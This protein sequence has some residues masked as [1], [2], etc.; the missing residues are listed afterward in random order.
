MTFLAL[1]HMWHATQ[2]MGRGGWWRF[3][4]FF[5]LAHMWHATQLIGWWMMTFL[6]LDM[7]HAT[8][9]V[10]DDVSCTRTHVTC[11]ATDRVGWM[12]T[13]SICLFP[14]ASNLP[15]LPVSFQAT[16][17]VRGKTNDFWNNSYTMDML[18]KRKT[19]EREVSNLPHL[20]MFLKPHAKYVEK[21][22]VLEPNLTS[23]TCCQ[24]EETADCQPLPFSTSFK[25][26]APANVFE[27]TRKIR[28][29]V[30]P[31]QCSFTNPNFDV[32]ELETSKN[33]FF[34]ES[35]V[36]WVLPFY[37][38]G[39]QRE[40]MDKNEKNKEGWERMEKEE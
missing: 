26:T 20:P 7:W 14:Q 15:L 18:R 31:L 17:Q 2:L 35:W 39:K 27:A 12:L 38:D 5:A 24:R 11:Y 16:R 28:G 30:R 23:W 25:F 33:C 3:L 21:Q 4:M 10:D 36:A 9:G 19:R 37:R 34:F 8:P 29:K 1:A 40:K 6:A 22:M 32:M 13:I